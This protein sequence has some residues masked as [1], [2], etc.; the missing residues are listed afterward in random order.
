MTPQHQ[1]HR[2]SFLITL[3]LAPIPESVIKTCSRF[4]P[5]KEVPREYGVYPEAVSAQLCRDITE[6]IKSDIGIPC[7]EVYDQL[8]LAGKLPKPARSSSDKFPYYSF[9]NYF[10][11]AHKFA[12]IKAPSKT[13]MI[14]RMILKGFSDKEIKM[15]L[16]CSPGAVDRI[17]TVLGY[18]GYKSRISDR[19]FASNVMD[20]HRRVSECASKSA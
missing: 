11:R 16:K 12:K 19:A 17:K 13:T 10:Y 1:T 6:I 3:G 18:P 8:D 9:K 7:A 4:D 20:A 15:A 5:P 2:P 14:V